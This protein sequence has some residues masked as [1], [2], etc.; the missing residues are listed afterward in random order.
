MS[1]QW[2]D[3]SIPLHAGMTVWPGDTPFQCIPA[4]RI[5]QGA[6]CNTSTLTLP[7]HT[8]THCDAPWHFEDS[9]KKLHEVDTDL[10]F[11]E[12]LL[13]DVAQVALIHAA[14]LGKAP[15][16]PRVLLKTRN[17]AYDAAK[18]F[19]EDFVA[20]APDA[21]QRMVDEGVRLI[22]IDYLSIAPF[23]D[24]A[25]THHLLLQNEVFIVEGLRLAGLSSGIYPFVV[26][27]MPLL[28]ADGAPCRAFVG[29]KATL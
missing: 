3:V 4:G 6:S 17:S 18:P 11:G 21:A 26:L 19:K 14:D 25:P 22:G 15:L 12:A 9:G 13:L 1:L 2:R 16:P 5:A 29:R 24:A 10:F 27:P 7:T 28:G 23:A 8:G 20:V